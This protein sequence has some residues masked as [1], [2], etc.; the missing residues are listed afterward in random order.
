MKSPLIVDPKDHKWLLL[1]TVIR[2]FD[3]RRV[4]QE[5]SKAG[6]NPVPLARIYLSII[7]VAMFF[8]L[9][10]TYV[11]SEIKKRPQ[12]RKFLNIRTVPSADWIY[13]FSSQFSDEQ[14]VALTNGILN[15]IKPKK[16]AKEPQTIIIDG[17]ALSIDL[18]WFRKKYTKSKLSSLPYSWGY[19]PSKGYYIGYK[20]TLAINSKSLLPLAFLLHSGSPNDSKIFPEIIGELVRRRILKENDCVILDRGYYAYENYAEPLLNHRI[21][22]LIIPK[23]NLN[24]RK[25]KNL[26]NSSIIWFNSSRVLEHIAK[27][28][29]LLKK[30]FEFLN[31]PTFRR[32]L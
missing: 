19:S 17:S 32:C 9:D 24:I 4:G 23:K 2:T 13:R 5:I 22:P 16:K 6:I 30:L 1:E 28:K 27:I 21:L 18:N 31:N 10:I 20:L 8:S 7:F 11:I 3:K 14:F 12:L 15:S 25:L 26:F 29:H